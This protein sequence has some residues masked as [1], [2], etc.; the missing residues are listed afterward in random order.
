MRVYTSQ[1]TDMTDPTAVTLTDKNTESSAP[2]RIAKWIAATGITGSV[3]LHFLGQVSHNHYL[4][5]WGVDPGPFPKTVYWNSVNGY[6]TLF[7]RIA[8]TFLSLAE[9]W[10]TIASLWTF[11]FCVCLYMVLIHVLSKKHD[12]E[13]VRTWLLSR[14]PKW[15]HVPIASFGIGTLVTFFVPYVLLVMALFLVIP[16]PRCQDSW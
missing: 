9:N 8:H 4:K 11:A 2:H 15:A 10:R 14:V 3:A 13:K 16:A 6:Y 12:P 5:L 7:D 1:V